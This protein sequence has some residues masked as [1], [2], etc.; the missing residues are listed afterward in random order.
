M[1]RQN[2]ILTFTNTLFYP[3]DPQ[4]DEVKIEDIA[5][6]LSQM[7]RANGHFKTFYSVAQHSIN[8]AQEAGIR[9]LSGR[10]QLACL[11]HDASEAYIS[12]I[13][14]PVKYYLDEYRKIEYKLQQV[15][16]SKFGLAE[17]TDEEVKKVEE[18]D[19]ALLHYE[20]EHLH[21]RA[22][23]EYSHQLYSLPDVAEKSMTFVEARFIQLAQQI[24]NNVVAGSNSYKCVGI[25][26][27]KKT[28]KYQGWAAFWQYSCGSYG[29]RVYRDI[30][31]LMAEHHDADCLLI[32]IP[33]GLPENTQDETARP[34]RE[35]RSR[36]KGKS[37]SVFNT[38]CRQAI[39]CQ[40]K[41]DA[42][43][44][45]LQFL[46]KSL[47]EQSLGFSPKIRE[48][49]QFL[50]DNPQF[51]GR[52]RE[53]HPEYGFAVLNYGRPIIS[54]KSESIGLNER[55][56]VLSQH[57]THTEKALNEIIAK[58]P[59]TLIDDFVDAMALAVIGQIGMHDGFETIPEQPKKDSRGLS[60]E[61]VYSRVI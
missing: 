40:D 12:D 57:F 55:K 31:E 39:Y 42:K 25:D 26:S 7:C 20:F 8:C 54:K 51:I 19:D 27:C 16:Y 36:L 11:L 32:D 53:S 6:A 43:A 50:F 13:T 18:I 34:D 35:L 28:G 58:Y 37:S 61:I 9:G 30:T 52:L 22:I 21:H 5:H 4:T 2:A 48:I 38:P 29:F 3:L 56:L 15:I 23:N 59:K 47:S 33:V 10:I 44:L 41:Q 1:T 49:D 14:R 46:N 60:M 45:N 24:M 17:L